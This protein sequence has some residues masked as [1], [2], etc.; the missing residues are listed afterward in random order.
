MAAQQENLSEELKKSL[1]YNSFEGLLNMLKESLKNVESGSQSSPID[2]FKAILAQSMGMPFE[3]N[4]KSNF[5]RLEKA[6]E[7]GELP[8]QLLNTQFKWSLSENPHNWALSSIISESVNIGSLVAEKGD[9]QLFKSLVDKGL[10]PNYDA[11]F[12]PLYYAV[13]YK[14]I[15]M[16]KFLVDKKDS[17]IDEFDLKEAIRIAKRTNN[18]SPNFFQGDD[19]KESQIVKILGDTIQALQSAKPAKKFD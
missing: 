18:S 6:L 17:C 2:L 4:G 1:K 15:E 7:T 19:S 12:N 10:Q 8:L 16:V 13:V 14:D 3:S 9:F 5:K 11:T